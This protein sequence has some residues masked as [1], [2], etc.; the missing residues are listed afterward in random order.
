MVKPTWVRSK[1]A[2]LEYSGSKRVRKIGVTLPSRSAVTRCLM[3]IGET[4]TVLEGRCGVIRTPV[5]SAE[6]CTCVQ[7]CQE[8]RM[9]HNR[10][11][12]S[13][14]ASAC[15]RRSRAELGTG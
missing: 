15:Q 8:S 7:R 13:D 12:G 4:F 6:V 14:A 5:T 11:R 2:K 1:E 9:N 3:A 10:D